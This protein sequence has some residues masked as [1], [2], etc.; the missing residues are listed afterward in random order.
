MIGFSK[1]FVSCYGAFISL[2]HYL[3]SFLC[4]FYSILA[5]VEGHFC[6]F[7]EASTRY[8]ILNISC[9]IRNN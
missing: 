1:F 2:R 7:D 3:S 8:G 5:L 6:G 4:W 9:S